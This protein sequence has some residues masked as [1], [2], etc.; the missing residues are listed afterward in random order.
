VIGQCLTSFLTLPEQSRH[1]ARMAW[2][3]VIKKI[4]IEIEGKKNRL[5]VRKVGLL[6]SLSS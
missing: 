6:S 3:G 2:R 1:L 5:R 4:K